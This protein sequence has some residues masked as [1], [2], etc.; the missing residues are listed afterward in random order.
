MAFQ[1][2]AWPTAVNLSW[3]ILFFYSI[4]SSV[5][6]NPLKLENRVCYLTLSLSGMVAKTGVYFCCLRLL[7]HSPHV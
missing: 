3:I 2:W 5:F 6:S 4:S 7:S 1:D